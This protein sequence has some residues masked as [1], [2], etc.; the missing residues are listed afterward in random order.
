LT[1]RATERSQEDIVAW[2]SWDTI[3]STFTTLCRDPSNCN[4]SAT[5][6]SRL[7]IRTVELYTRRS[8]PV[9]IE[10]YCASE[11]RH[12]HDCVQC[13]RLQLQPDRC[14]HPPPKHLR[15][16]LHG[17]SKPSNQHRHSPTI[18]RALDLGRTNLLE[19]LPH[20]RNNRSLPNNNN[21][22]N[23]RTKTRSTHNRYSTV[24]PIRVH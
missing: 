24:H 3:P 18:R 5:P 8:E 20:R 13:M 21:H 23:T 2:V 9:P 14:Q 16:S 17:P 10:R 6:G 22:Q 7:F 19:R 15:H 1:G 12:R 11:D 4:H